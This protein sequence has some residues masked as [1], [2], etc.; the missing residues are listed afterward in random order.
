MPSS[1][2]TLPGVYIEVPK[3]L[4]MRVKGVPVGI[5]GFIGYCVPRSKGG[6]T[7]EWP[8]AIDSMEQIGDVIDI[9]EWSNLNTSIRAH[10]LH[11]GQRCYVVGV[12]YEFPHNPYSILGGGEPG[13]RWGLAAF[14]ASEEVELLSA[15]DLYVVPDGAPAPDLNGVLSSVACLLDFCKGTRLEDGDS[16]SQGGY[17][18]LLDSPPELSELA[19]LEFVRLL[20]NHPYSDHM[21]FYYPWIDMMVEGKA[22]RM[23][24]SGCVSGLLSGQSAPPPGSPPGTVTVSSGPHLG[25]GN[26]VLKD[27]IGAELLMKRVE[28]RDLLD[29]GV[30][31]IVNWPTRG[32]VVWGTR[33][34]SPQKELNHISVR[35]ILNF[36][37]RAVYYGTQWAVFEPNTPSLWKRISSKVGF[38]LED[39]YNAGILVGE[40]ADGAFIVKCDEETNPPEQRDDGIVNIIIMVRPVRATELIVIQI[41]QNSAGS[42]S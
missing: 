4:D 14:D 41:S 33:T 34:L 2:Y 36:I 19:V 15:P 42:G 6:G 35:R 3:V 27:V 38:F 31:C 17:F 16:C 24:A 28:V 9:P 32:M 7:P 11:G 13:K 26:H 30:T 39:L 20:R 21:A 5:T 40:S 8:V 1:S 10:F 29:L 23:P 22:I 12:P 18:L 37:R 25:A